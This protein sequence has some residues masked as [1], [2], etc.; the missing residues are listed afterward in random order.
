VAQNY[1]PG[2]NDRPDMM[3]DG[4][5]IIYPRLK[6]FLPGPENVFASLG[7]SWANVANT[8]FR[9]WKAKMYE[10]GICTPFIAH[11]PK[12][13]KLKGGTVYDGNCHL[14]DIMAT[15]LELSG[16][17]YPKEFDGRT[18]LPPEGKS[19]VPIFKKG[20]REGHDILGFEHFGERALI[21][22]DWKIV[23]PGHKAWELYNLRTDRTEMHNVAD[24]YP[25]IVDKLAASYQAWAVRTLVEPSPK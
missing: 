8:P 7:P 16:A 5:R 18:I 19:F 1:S 9:F 17:T 2:E 3:R 13:I 4:T 12:G 22:G 11:F 21:A 24:T 15:A 23:S 6:R 14:I 25:A 10:G 20:K